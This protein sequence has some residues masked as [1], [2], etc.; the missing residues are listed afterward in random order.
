MNIGFN[1]TNLFD[2]GK[3]GTVYPTMTIK[4]EWGELVVSSGD[5][6]LVKDWQIAYLPLS[7]DIPTGNNKIIEGDGWKLNLSP[8]WKVI[9]DGSNFK[10]VK[11]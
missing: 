7:K 5:G 8:G 3:Y 9:A 4:D 2:L 6:G 1:P 11:E 10:V